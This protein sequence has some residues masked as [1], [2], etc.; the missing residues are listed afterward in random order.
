MSKIGKLGTWQ[1]AKVRSYSKAPVSPPEPD[2]LAL[3][4]I[5]ALGRRALRPTPSWS[6]GEAIVKLE[7]RAALSSKRKDPLR[8][9]W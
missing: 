6:S 7:A 2:S 9:V 4:A 8:D 1:L 3:P 5:R